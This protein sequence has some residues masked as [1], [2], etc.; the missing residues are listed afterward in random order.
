MKMSRIRKKFDCVTYKRRVQ[1]E[2][3]EEIKGLSPQEEIEYFRKSAQAGPLGQ[4]WKA[5]KR[6][7]E[8]AGRRGRRRQA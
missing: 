1:S 3:Y 2:I 5:V 8:A 4:W 7:S 6:R